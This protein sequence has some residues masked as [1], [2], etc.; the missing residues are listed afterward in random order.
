MQTIKTSSHASKAHP[1]PA[2]IP[3]ASIRRLMF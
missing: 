2:E 3:M 1:S